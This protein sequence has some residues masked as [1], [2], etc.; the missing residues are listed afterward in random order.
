MKMVLQKKVQPQDKPI[1]IDGINSSNKN[2]IAEGA[3]SLE[4]RLEELESRPRRNH[5]LH[6]SA[7]VIALLSLILLSVWVFSS[8]GP[9]PAVWVVI[10]I[11]IGI[12]SLIEFFTRS[13]FRW[14]RGAYLRSHFFDFVAIVPVLA[15][16]NHGF[17]IQMV[18]VG[19]ILVARFV[20][21]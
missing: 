13:G 2:K 21:V 12:I 18:W 11:V 9:V 7:F 15:L 17:V 8:H 16:V 10:D 5:L 19:I 4:A 3:A 14:D 20:R 1:L 6:W